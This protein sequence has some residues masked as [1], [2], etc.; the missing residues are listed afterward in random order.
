[1]GEWQVINYAAPKG[2]EA[3]MR[4]SSSFWGSYRASRHRVRSLLLLEKSRRFMFRLELSRVE[5]PRATVLRMLERSADS[6]HDRRLFETDKMKKLA[7]SARSA[8]MQARVLYEE[9]D[10][11]R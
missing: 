2:A 5:G 8:E 7:R 10:G 3:Q 1:M 4:R 11:R 9:S 6:A